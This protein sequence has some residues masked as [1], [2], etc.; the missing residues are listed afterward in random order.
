MPSI[1]FAYI[2]ARVMQEA[3]G[4]RHRWRPG[5]AIVVVLAGLHLVFA[6]V[7]DQVCIAVVGGFQGRYRALRDGVAAVVDFQHLGPQETK[8]FFLDWHQRE[9]SAV[10]G[11]YLRKALPTGVT[12]Y[13]P[14]THSKTMSY[15]EK[16]QGGLGAERIHYYSL[17]LLQVPYECVKVNDHEL[18]I[19]PKEGHFFSTLFE[20]LYTTGA[21]YHAG[22]VFDNGS[23]KATIELV[24]PANE[25]KR[26]RFTFPEPLS[27]PNYRF[28]MWDGARFVPARF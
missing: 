10:Y 26:V 15:E 5:R 28:L 18:V 24:T 12:D 21:R 7:L 17:S 6:P 16:L 2:V 19:S 8:V 25:V 22:Q 9:M 3:W 4:R 1:A 23:F 11:L 27:S 13:T 14:W 20:Q